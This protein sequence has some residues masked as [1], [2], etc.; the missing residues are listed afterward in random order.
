MLVAYGLWA[1]REKGAALVDLRLFGNRTFE[2]ATGAMFLINGVTFA[3]QMLIPL[4]VTTARGISPTETGWLMM[5]LGAGMICTYFF[6]S[7]R[8]RVPSG[9]NTSRTILARWR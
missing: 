6:L 9:A 7:C 2:T 4:F 1:R 8:S 3:G 5:P